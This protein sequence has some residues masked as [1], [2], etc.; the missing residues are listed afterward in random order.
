MPVQ[1]DRIYKKYEERTPPSTKWI[2]MFF[3]IFMGVITGNLT[4]NWIT[5]K[6]AEYELKKSLE[7]M[8]KQLKLDAERAK[9]DLEQL[10]IRN[11]RI[12]EEQRR[13]QQQQGEARIRE[14]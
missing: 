1:E 2:I 6:I 9:K 7:I 14:N 12:A 3:V 11:A 5:A 8:S 4:S 10:Q 13:H